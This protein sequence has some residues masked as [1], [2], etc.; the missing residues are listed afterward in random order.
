MKRSSSLV[1]KDQLAELRGTPEYRHHLFGS[2][3]SANAVN[4][5]I[6]EDHDDLATVTAQD[7]VVA[8]V[9]H[10]LGDLRREEPS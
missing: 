5:Q 7:G 9:D 6:T 10:Q 1:T 2:L 4:P 8:G 3:D